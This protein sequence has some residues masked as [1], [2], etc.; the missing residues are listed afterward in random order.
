[1]APVGQVILGEVAA[2]APPE[3]PGPE[4]EEALGVEAS[5][6]FSATTSMGTNFL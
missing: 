2:A 5:A 6:N 4:L 3:H 1:M